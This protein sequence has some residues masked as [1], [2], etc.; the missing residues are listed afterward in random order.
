MNPEGASLYRQI[1]EFLLD[2]RHPDQLERV[3][4]KLEKDRMSPGQIRR[5]IR[6][7]QPWIEKQIREGNYLPLPPKMEDLGIDQK[8]FQIQM[9]HLCERPDVPFSM[10]VTDGVHHLVIVGKPESGKTVS[11]KVYLTGIE[12]WNL[13]HPDDPIHILLYDFKNDFL[14]PHMI[15]GEDITYVTVQ[16]RQKTRLGFNPPPGAP[17]TSWAGWL[18]MVLAARLGLIVSRTALT[19]VFQW[20]NPYLN[21]NNSPNGLSSAPSLPLIL[22]VLKNSIA[23]LWAEKPD[24]MKFLMQMLSAVC[25]DSG[26]LFDTENGFQINSVFAS[27]KHCI[28]NMAN[29]NPSYLRYL[30]CDLILLQLM[31]YVI[32]NNKKTLRTKYCVVFEEA[33]FFVRP[34]AQAAYPEMLS[35]ITYVARLAREYGIQLVICISGLQNLAP[36]LA[37]G[38]DIHII[39]KSTDADSIRIIRN[40]L[41]IEKGLEKLL[42]AL[43]P[44]QAIVRYAS[45]PYPYPFLVQMNHI[46]PDHTPQSRPFDSVPFIAARRLDEIPELKQALENLIKENQKTTIRQNQAKLRSSLNTT[47]RTFLD[48]LSLHEP[49]PLHKIFARTDKLSPATEQAILKKLQTLQYIDLEQIRTS[50]SSIRFAM[51]TDRGL[52]YLNKQSQYP[53]TRGGPAHR[54]LCLYKQ[55][56]DLKHGALSAECDVRIPGANGGCTD[57]LTLKKDGYHAT[58]VIIHCETNIIKHVRDCLLGNQQI[59]SLTFIVCLKSDENK[60]REQILSDPDLVFVQNKIHFMTVEQLLKETL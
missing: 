22:D 35:V 53:K 40:T 49:E 47:E 14:N 45:C 28:I 11:L 29:C 15:L 27:K 16:D 48:T 18:S 34:A 5:W 60:I 3:V 24:Y 25:V 50:K 46:P 2:Y 38:V 19:T 56:L 37:S 12:A 8:P 31:F 54:C 51:I 21:T 52:E 9:G 7:I 17:L 57:V 44:G 23:I 1:K 43:V 58:E 30:I 55:Q 20:T 39:H 4:K 42:P 59:K 33:D 10:N 6:R 32:Q 26:G 13:A 36:D 41:G